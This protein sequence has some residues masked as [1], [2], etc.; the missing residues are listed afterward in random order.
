MTKH[1]SHAHTHAY[2]HAHTH[3]HTHARTY[4]Y[5]HSLSL[6]HTRT[7]WHSHISKEVC[8]N[9]EGIQEGIP[10]RHVTWQLA[11][12]HKSEGG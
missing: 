6:T 10:M 9:V 12:K 11:Q 7:Q 3:A 1:C 5:T 2:T 8:V 4:T